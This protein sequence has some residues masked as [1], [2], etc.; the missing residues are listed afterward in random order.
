MTAIS[1]GV[2]P[3]WWLRKPWHGR[4]EGTARLTFPGPF[5]STAWEALP[6]ATPPNVY[7]NLPQQ[8]I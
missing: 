5:H 3:H 8:T 1:Y 6:L 4:E 2:T 7:L